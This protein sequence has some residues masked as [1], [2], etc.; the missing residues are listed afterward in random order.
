MKTAKSHP[1]ELSLIKNTSYS[2]TDC[3]LISL[4]TF[5]LTIEQVG[6]SFFTSTPAWVN[7]LLMLRDKL[8][9]LVGLKTASDVDNREYLFANF[10]CKVGEKIALFKVLNK[11]DH[12]VIFGENDKHLDFRVSLFL[13]RPNNTLAV[14]TFVKTHNWKGTVY[15]LFVKPFHKIIVPTITKRMARQLQRDFH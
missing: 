4:N 1:P 3:Y 7:T 15:L 9:A 10:Q 6:K 12:E 5:G 14:S 8:G 2:Y 13:D 11:N